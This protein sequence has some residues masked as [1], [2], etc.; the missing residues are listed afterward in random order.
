MTTSLTSTATKLIA[1]PHTPCRQLDLFAAAATTTPSTA[2]AGL[3]VSM[4]Y[5]PCPACGAVN[6]V[7]GS[8]AAMHCGRLNCAGCGAFGGWLPKSAYRL[9]QATLE[10]GRPTTPIIIERGS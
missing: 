1:F 7:I 5:A 4:I 6:F 8:S 3:V 9:I 2:I 10:F